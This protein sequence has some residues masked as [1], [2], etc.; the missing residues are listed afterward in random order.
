MI[1]NCARSSSTRAITVCDNCRTLLFTWYLPSWTVTI[2]AILSSF[3]FF[4]LLKYFSLYVVHL[5]VKVCF[6]TLAVVCNTHWTIIYMFLF[7]TLFQGPL[8]FPN[9]PIF[10]QGGGIGPHLKNFWIHPCSCM[11][12]CNS[13]TWASFTPLCCN[14]SDRALICNASRFICCGVWYKSSVRDP[15]LTHF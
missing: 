10:L 2:S 6:C 5:Q 4:S 8:F 11:I 14:L 13:F 3:P 15:C 9:A 1:E 7:Y 12:D